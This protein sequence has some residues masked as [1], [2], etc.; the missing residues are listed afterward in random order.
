MTTVVQS[1]PPLFIRD[2]DIG[3]TLTPYEMCSNIV[4][5]S[6]P[7]KL[8][9]VQKIN[10]IWR[11]Y[12]KDAS[13]RLELAMK[14]RILIAGKNVPLYDVN[15]NHS[16]QPMY[17][18]IPG[19]H[20]VT[21]SDKLTIKHLPLSVSNDDIKAMLLGLDVELMSPIKYGFVRDED[22][23]LTQY[24][25][26][27][28]FVFVKS[29]DQLVPRH[30][31]VGIFPCVVIHHGKEIRCNACGEKG[32][33]VADKSCKAKPKNEI[34]AFKSYEHPLSNHFPCELEVFDKK[35]KNVEE[36]YFWRMSSEMGN[37]DLAK[38][39]L[40][41]RHAGEAKRLSKEI[42]DDLTRLKWEKENVDIME[43]LLAAKAS[44]CKRFCECLM[45]SKETVLAEATPSK[46]WGTGLSIFVTKN[47]SESCW[48]G[49][50]ML[51]AL[52]MELR[53]KLILKKGEESNGRMEESTGGSTS[54]EPVSSNSGDFVLISEEEQNESTTVNSD[55][56]MSANDTMSDERLPVEA[57]TTQV[58]QTSLLI[59]VADVNDGNTHVPRRPRERVPHLLQANRHRSM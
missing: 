29:L 27:D 12:F 48:P 19:T 7:S 28:R 49:Q 38:R 56:A 32:H 18:G 4:R 13:T 57:N 10:N 20:V 11:V 24:K 39:I 16:S 50:N 8:E 59:D 2:A 23:F 25:S 53:A 47:C 45:E 36:A 5:A 40:E 21:Q 1:V 34:L 35:F 14:E 9:G 26:G 33:K 31:K 30:Q 41:S 42:A 58:T 52:L 17:R 54:N 46:F 3:K 43:H 44:Q 15:P 6:S 22:G 51:G 55:V 37:Q